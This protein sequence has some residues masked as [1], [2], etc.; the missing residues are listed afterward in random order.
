MNR[1]SLSVNNIKCG[2][3]ENSIQLKLE[4]IEGVSDVK[5]DNTNGTVEFTY[6]DEA[7]VDQVRRSLKKMGYTEDD[8]NTMDTAKS[9]VNCMI[10]RVKKG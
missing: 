5:A 9:Y 7:S 10:G 3:C 6:V 4:A 8:P 1:K 2:G